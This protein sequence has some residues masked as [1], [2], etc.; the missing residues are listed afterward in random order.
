MKQDGGSLDYYDYTYLTT[1]SKNS[2]AHSTSYLKVNDRFFIQGE[3]D[4]NP[5]L[6]LT[7]R[8]ILLLQ[9]G[10]DGSIKN[11]ESNYLRNFRENYDY[12][13]DQY[14]IQW[15]SRPIFYQLLIL[16]KANTK[17]EVPKYLIMNVQ[18]DNYLAFEY[19][20]EDA[21]FY[22]SLILKDGNNAIGMMKIIDQYYFFQ[23]D[24]KTGQCKLTSFNEY[25]FKEVKM[26][27]YNN[28]PAFL[29]DLV[30]LQVFSSGYAV[31]DYEF[32]STDITKSFIRS[33]FIFE[34]T[35]TNQNCYESFAT[36]NTL[37]IIETTKI[38]QLQLEGDLANS[39]IC[40]I[41]KLNNNKCEIIYNGQQ[42]TN[43][44]T[45]LNQMIDPLEKEFYLLT[46]QKNSD[47]E[48][49]IKIY[50]SVI[51]RQQQTKMLYS[52]NEN[53]VLVGIMSQYL[54]KGVTKMQLD[55]NPNRK[56]YIYIQLTQRKYQIKEQKLL[57]G[58]QIAQQNYMKQKH[59]FL[60]LDANSLNQSALT[61][62]NSYTFL[63]QLKIMRYRYKNG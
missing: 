60:Q 6:S 5:D 39:S 19:R 14:D 38:G 43:Q 50:C 35:Q 30:K 27:Q 7:T 20:N 29:S 15:N 31:K 58:F 33:G 9:V 24:F 63:V 57:S 16:I 42:S 54:L 10:Y 59:L 21:K 2:R 17:P 23:F 4:I 11:P 48:G 28:K 51:Q 34:H 52:N 53:L 36:Q 18:K 8:E 26:I 56:I 47:F 25:D 40:Q 13:V 61:L 62:D 45:L 37:S 46:F 3:F 49:T 12:K 22:N 44:I 1:N 55:L 32:H 41:D